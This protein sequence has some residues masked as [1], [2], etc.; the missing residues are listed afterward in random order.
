MVDKGLIFRP[1]DEIVLE[2]FADAD[3]A[4]LWNSEDP[5]DPTCVKSRTGYLICLGNVP[6]VWKSKL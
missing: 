3:F 2:A 1:Q 5:Q 6:V 4:G